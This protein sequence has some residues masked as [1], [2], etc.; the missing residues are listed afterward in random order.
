MTERLVDIIDERC[1]KLLEQVHCMKVAKVIAV[2][3]AV[4][5]AKPLGNKGGLHYP[6]LPD[7]PVFHLLGGASS[8][9][10]PI[11]EGDFCLVF[12]SDDNSMSYVASQDIDFK[13]TPKH[14]L[15]DG[16]ALVGLSQALTIPTDTTLTGKLIHDGDLTHTGNAEVTG[17]LT[18]T[19]STTQTG[20]IT[21]TGTV[22]A[23]TGAF[24]TLGTATMS[25]VMIAG[26]A[27][28][29]AAIPDG[30][31]KMMTFSNGILVRYS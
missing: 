15:S 12:F 27:G 5:D 1:K 14:R 28:I 30:T 18:I 24:G 23:P 19:G 17:D 22:T 9:T 20:D 11:K 13:D 16:F 3:G 6:V 29:S 26:Q 25:A 31:G 10:M 21:A 2:K 7:L 8:L 4:I